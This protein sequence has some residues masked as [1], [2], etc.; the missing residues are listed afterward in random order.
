MF[1]V[2]SVRRLLPCAAFAGHS[3]PL[4]GA[5]NKRRASLPVRCLALPR[6]T[7]PAS[8]CCR[9]SGGRENREARRQ[10]RRFRTTARRAYWNSVPVRAVRIGSRPRGSEAG[11]RPRQQPRTLAARG[12][13]TAAGAFS[14][15]RHVPASGSCP[16][17]ALGSSSLRLPVPASYLLQLFAAP[18]G[19]CGVLGVFGVLA[20]R[21]R[22]G[23]RRSPPAKN[24]QGKGVFYCS[25]F[26]ANFQ[27]APGA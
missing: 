24:S 21:V 9:S 13:A 16:L 14:G 18:V 7:L 25:S 20:P 11:R 19:V 5:G 6:S 15:A 12:S 3:V 1:S 10:F 2:V 4:I 17:A 23:S 8:A 26:R 27:R 22:T